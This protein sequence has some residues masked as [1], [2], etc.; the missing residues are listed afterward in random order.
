MSNINLYLKKHKILFV[1]SI[2]ILIFALIFGMPSL[3]KLK[4]RTTLYTTDSWDGTIASS[5][6][7]GDGTKDNPY[8]VKDGE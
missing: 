6:Q 3:A 2:T 5:Y 4:N 1:A 8:I 7:K